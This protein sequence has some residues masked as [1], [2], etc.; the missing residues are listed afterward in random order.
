M[1]NWKQWL[2][3]HALPVGVSGQMVRSGYVEL[4]WWWLAWYNFDCDIYY[5][6]RAEQWWWYWCNR[7]RAYFFRWL[8]RKGIWQVEDGHLLWDGKFVRPPQPR[9]KR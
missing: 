8:K 2:D 5:T 4:E 6:W 9:K 1:E 7:P 3:P